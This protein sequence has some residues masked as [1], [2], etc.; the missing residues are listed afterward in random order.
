[1]DDKRTPDLSNPQKIA[2]ACAALMWKTDKCSQAMGMRLDAVGSGTAM[3][4]MVVKADMLN[5]QHN[6][7]G[8][9]MFTLA[10]S[11][12]AFA[13]NGYNQFTVA[14]HCSISF[15]KPAREH[16]TLIATAV[17]RWRE[18]RSG[19]YDVTITR[20]DEV[21]AE[22]RG[23]SRTVRGQMFPDLQS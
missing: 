3:L 13:C 8:G 21:I 19:I 9:V 10:D 23:N 15:L 7:H 5:G 17:E 4:S 16:D 11:A 22:F 20:N 14:Q 1:M 18:G 12:F 6:C 2:E